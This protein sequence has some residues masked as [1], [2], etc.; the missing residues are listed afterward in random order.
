MDNGNSVFP[1][2]GRGFDRTRFVLG[3]AAFGFA[4]GSI[5]SL[6]RSSHNHVMSRKIVEPNVIVRIDGLALIIFLKYSTSL[7]NIGATSSIRN[8]PDIG[9]GGT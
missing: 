1:I 9:T 3:D 7:R 5:P 6:I 8:L 2:F 4:S